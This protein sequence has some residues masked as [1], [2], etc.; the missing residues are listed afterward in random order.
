MHD[1]FLS[2]PVG[3]GAGAAALVVA[4]ALLLSACGGGDS[5]SSDK[6]EKVPGADTGKQSASPSASNAGDGIKR[7][8]VVLPKGVSDVFEGGK[9]GDPKKD[10]VLA[11]NARNLDA[12]NA[13]ITTDA[14]KLTPALRFYNKDDALTSALSYIQGFYDD[15]RSYVGAAR[16]YNRKV[17][18]LKGGAVALTY[19]QDATKTYPKDRRTGKVTHPAASSGDYTFFNERLE[20]NDK[21]VWQ[22]AS[23]ISGAGDQKCT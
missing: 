1:T 14:K 6:A 18:P 2:R 7:P 13:A 9:T 22:S 20:K 16:Y 4:A 10:A 5:A 11:D 17:T 12:I 23:V 19:C 21:G 15:G 8:K 3:R